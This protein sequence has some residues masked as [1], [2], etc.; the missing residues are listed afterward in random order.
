MR[1]GC[2]FL[3]VEV[4]P[5][6]LMPSSLQTI[7]LIGYCQMNG[8]TFR[9]LF[10]VA[11]VSRQAGEMWRKLKEYL[12][13]LN[14][15][16]SVPPSTDEHELC[17]QRISTRFFIVIFTA[18]LLI[19]LLYNSLVKVTKTDSIHRPSFAQYT[20]LNSTYS[21]TLTCPCSEISINYEKFLRVHYTL[22]Q[23][24]NSRFVEQTWIEY[25]AS[26]Q[27]EMF[28]NDFRITSPYAFQGLR[29]LC[30]LSNRT[31][32]DSCTQFYS[33]KY[34]SASVVSKP[35]FESETNSLTDQ[36]RSSVTKSFS[37]SLS[38]IR[39]TT[40]I[41]ALVSVLK[42]NHY[43]VY[44]KDD[45]PYLQVGGSIHGGC[46]CRDSSTCIASSSI[47]RYPNS[48]VL[49]DIPGFYIGCFVVDSL[50][51][52]TLE[53]FYNQSC[54]ERVQSYIDSSSSM[55]VTALDPSLSKWY[56]PNT[57]IQELV[58][59]L[60]I[61][62]WDVSTTYEQY[63]NQ[64]RPSQCSYTFE[65]GN[66]VIYIVT[67]LFGIAGGLTTVLKFILPRL[68]KLV[69]KTR[70]QQQQVTGKFM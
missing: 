52:S 41:N 28:L 34:V 3:Y 70:T 60:M 46:R 59:K 15:F 58:D 7:P 14:L 24:C 47:R 43:Y 29:A 55:N 51:Q 42:T 2:W 12:R 17:S 69:R 38:L 67:T 22:H 68:V 26:S 56:S 49:F 54:I 1:S 61:E 5:E 6:M 44:L 53:C 36:L 21:L 40:Y 30:L 20:H 37:L 48:T 16:I 50:L 35:M 45:S 65:T 57:T 27:S 39:N 25:L 9:C 62:Q 32:Y 63:Y 11:T 13:N 10:L 64:C 18:A 8:S 66:D 23:V 4:P 33:N 31:I 19:L